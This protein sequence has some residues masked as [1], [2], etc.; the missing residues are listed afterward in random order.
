MKL[1]Q[2]F[3]SAYQEQHIILS[4]GLGI[5][6]L[7]AG[8]GSLTASIMMTLAFAANL[9]LTSSVMFFIR[10]HLNVESKFILSLIIMATVSLWIQRLAITFL[11]GWVQGLEMYLPLLAISGLIAARVETVALTSSYKE[12]IFDALGTLVGFASLVIPLGLLVDL[13]GLGVVQLHTVS[14]SS[15]PTYLWS[16]QL[17]S[18][19]WL[20]PI[21]Q[22][23]RGGIGMLL[24]AS[25]WIA[26]VQ[27]FRGR[28]V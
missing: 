20:I 24:I 23:S 1:P 15:Q 13:L 27:R 14:L 7:L 9:I 19:P 25:L 10:R 18:S 11:P 6:I 22:G 3:K 16:W 21:F 26:L 4:L 12:T 8:G 28:T 2:A 17:L 5:F